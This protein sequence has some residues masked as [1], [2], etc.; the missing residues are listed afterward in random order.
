MR[1]MAARAIVL[2][3][4][5]RGK[6]P[7]EMREAWTCVLGI[8]GERDDVQ[9]G[10]QALWG[11]WSFTENTGLLPECLVLA[12]RFCELAKRSI[13]PA[14]LAI[15]DRLVGVTLHYLGDQAAAQTY[16]GRSLARL[17]PAVHG[18]SFGPFSI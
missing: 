10:L 18:T 15:G 5:S 11:L 2:L 6:I 1:L 12:K 8:A 14:D 17:G 16:I 13:D 9:Y 3:Y 4:T 7:I